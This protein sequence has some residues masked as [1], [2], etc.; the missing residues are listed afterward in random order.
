M[1]APKGWDEGILVKAPPGWDEAIPLGGQGEGFPAP[2][3]SLGEI[4]V[5]EDIAGDPGKIVRHGLPIAAGI[6]G[7]MLPG[8]GFIAG[9]LAAGATD[10]A[11]SKVYGEGGD[12]GQRETSFL[13]DVGAGLLPTVAKGA[14][15]IAKKII[16]APLETKIASTIKYGIQKGI[17]PTVVGKSNFPQTEQYYKKAQSAVESIIE[18]KTGLQFVDDAGNTIKGTLP[19][20]LGQFSQS[21][22]QTKREI[23]R[24]YDDMVKASGLV[25]RDV[26]LSPI[27]S[28][29]ESFAGN[30][31]SR[32]VGGGGPGRAQEL[33][34]NMSG[35]RLTLSEAQD[36]IAALNGR[37]KSFYRNPSPDTIG[38]AAA[39]ALAANKLRSAVDSAVEG[40]GYQALKNQYGA[41]REI[42][43]EVSSRALVDARKNIK[44][45][46]DFADIASAAEAARAI[47]TFNTGAGAAA[48]AIKGM[49][50]WYKYINNP[51]RIVKTM[52]TD[53]EKLIMKRTGG[54]PLKALPP[55]SRSMPGQMPESYVRGYS[56][57]GAAEGGY[58]GPRALGPSNLFSLPPI[59]GTSAPSLMR[60]PRSLLFDQF[61]LGASN[62]AYQVTD[63]E[64]LRAIRSVPKR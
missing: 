61:G 56:S 52:F 48:G 20:N 11:L 7:G 2:S 39:D 13:T 25:G 30:K 49:K 24:K 16:P 40:Y 12:A 18:N 62:P 15:G 9:P 47:A 45:L 4:T 46:I 8:A 42:E 1:A 17:R 31:V 3:I 44:G 22:D 59:G 58:L 38:S 64:L 63:E 14:Y 36:L 50:E 54:V 37:L 29:L 34:R 57:A 41:L 33:M 43:K 55:G 27:V 60:G 35:Q 32:M 19:A 6:V 51:N 28:E 26:D 53:A 21:I 5:G 10:L 23:F